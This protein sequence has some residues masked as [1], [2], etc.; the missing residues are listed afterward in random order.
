M[1]VRPEEDPRSDGG[2]GDER[3][4]LTGYLRDYRLTLEL[5]CSGL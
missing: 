5:K 4:T 1:F 3:H 2:L